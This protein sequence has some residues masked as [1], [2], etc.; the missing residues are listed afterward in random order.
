V[1]ALKTQ[2]YEGWRKVECGLNFS[3]Y[4][5]RRRECHAADALNLGEATVDK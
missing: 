4:W 2:R 5:G 3:A 1:P